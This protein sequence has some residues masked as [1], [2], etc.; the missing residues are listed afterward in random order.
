MRRTV[1]LMAAAILAGGGLVLAQG[2]R[3]IASP[4]GT[5]ATEVH[6]K[7]EKGSE[8]PEYHGGK[9]IEILYGRPLRRGRDLFGGTGANYGKTVNPDAPVWRAGANNTTRLRT[10]LPLVINGTTVAP[11]E[12]TMF[13]DLKP[14]NWTLI[15]SRWPAQKRYDPSNKNEIWGAYGYTADKDVVRVPMTLSTLPHSVEQLTWE[16][17]DVT[18]AG[19]TMAM[20]W[21]T[22]MASVPFKIGG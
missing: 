11:G 22:Q 2:E 19:G 6:G 1:M 9:W 21:G 8:G 13:I 15:V 12:Y 7:Y 14:N 4:A 16:F 10:E 3:H 20:S 17:L 18:D 5:A